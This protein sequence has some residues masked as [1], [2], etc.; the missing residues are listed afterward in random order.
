MV[1]D[2]EKYKEEDDR[3]KTELIK[4]NE[5]RSVI[6]S[7]LKTVLNKKVLRI[8][9]SE[10]KTSIS[11]KVEDIQNRIDESRCINR[12]SMKIG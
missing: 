4:R 8:N 6:F 7:K 5:V 1:N 3:C 2:A 10:D 9:L 11:E 12:R